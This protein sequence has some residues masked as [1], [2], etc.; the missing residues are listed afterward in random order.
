MTVSHR[1]HTY[2]SHRL[3]IL[4]VFQELLQTIILILQINEVLTHLVS[5]SLFI[6]DILLETLVALR[7]G[8]G[9]LHATLHVLHQL[10]QLPVLFIFLLECI[11]DVLVLRLHLTDDSV[12]LLELFLNDFEF[13]WVSECVLRSYDFLKLVSQ[14]GTLIHVDLHFD[15]DLLQTRVPNVTPQALVFFALAR[16]LC[17]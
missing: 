13:L 4:V 6:L 12:S 14:S 8:L 11:R 3:T 1:R 5:F 17:L 7:C 15:F 2:W 10:C 16:T 9:F